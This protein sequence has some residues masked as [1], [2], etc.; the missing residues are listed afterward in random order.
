MYLY[1]ENHFSRTKANQSGLWKNQMPA[2]SEIE[3]C[4]VKSRDE[5]EIGGPFEMRW[6]LMDPTRTASAKTVLKRTN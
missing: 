6:N 2:T 3:F 4:V 1:D 5:R